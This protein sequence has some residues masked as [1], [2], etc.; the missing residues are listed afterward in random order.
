MFHKR[1]PKPFLTDLTTIYAP[2]HPSNYT[3]LTISSNGTTEASVIL[4][5]NLFSV[6]VSVEVNTISIGVNIF[7]SNLTLERESIL[8]EIINSVRYFC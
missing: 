2:Y 6:N 1:N 3:T 7:Y 4:P 5:P 8:L